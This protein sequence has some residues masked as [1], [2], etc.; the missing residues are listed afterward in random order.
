MR[1]GGM[2]LFG[3]GGM[4][5]GMGSPLMTGLMAG[6]LGYLLGSNSNQ[7]VSP[8]V[9]QVMPAPGYAYPQPT[10]WPPAAPA[11]NTG[12]DGGTLAQLKL[13]GQLHDSG[14]L[15]DDEFVREKGRI[16]GS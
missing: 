8:Q 3:M 11:S 5:M 2:P 6:G 1:R 9:Q 13:L 16:L 15:T 14:T 4:G 7:Q 12:A 10:Q